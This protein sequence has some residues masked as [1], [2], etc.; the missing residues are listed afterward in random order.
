[1]RVFTRISDPRVVVAL[2]AL[3]TNAEFDAARAQERLDVAYSVT[4]LGLP[5]ANISWTVNLQDSRFSAA[6]SGTTAGLMKVFSN[7]SGNVS[8]SGT[9]SVGQ[10]LA[11]NYALSIVA[12]QWSDD[13]QISYSGGKAKET[14]AVP[15]PPN[16]NRVPLTDAHR[17]GVI[18]PM[19]ALLIPVPGTVNPV[20]PEACQQTVAVFDGRTRFDLKLAFRRLD[21]VKSDQ[22]YRGAAVVCSVHFSPIAGYD[23][24]RFL[25]KYLA[26]ERNIELW[27]VPF[28]GSRLLVP[29]RISL[30][31]P[32]GL[33]V[34]QATRFV[35]GQSAIP[36]LRG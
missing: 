14:L 2:L 31:T 23:P 6:A 32:L 5:I 24:N 36:Q 10:P 35:L 12:G 15:P 17:T 20:A 13:V 1:V 34:L 26:A 28:G 9:V 30:P 18:D 22:G 27:L 19:T 3:L 7:G 33:G 4:L 29:Y 21:T 16:P 8:A 25:V 11:A